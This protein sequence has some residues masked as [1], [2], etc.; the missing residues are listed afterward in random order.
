MVLSAEILLPC[1]RGTVFRYARFKHRCTNC[2]VSIVV[3][4][5]GRPPPTI[6]YCFKTDFFHTN[7]TQGWSTAQTLALTRHDIIVGSVVWLVSPRA[8]SVLSGWTR[9]GEDNMR[10]NQSPANADR[11][12]SQHHLPDFTDDALAGWWYKG[13]SHKQQGCERSKRYRSSDCGAHGW[14]DESILGLL[15]SRKLAAAMM[16]TSLNRYWGRSREIILNL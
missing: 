15:Y 10:E 11:L 8:R 1:R 14:G 2:G 3:V 16:H 9:V 5:S 13:L 6:Q 7:R 12:K 4:R